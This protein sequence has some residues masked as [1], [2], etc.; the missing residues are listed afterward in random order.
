[1]NAPPPL[2]LNPKAQEFWDRHHDR[3]TAAGIL[4]PADVDSFAVLCV[5]WGKI[6]ALAWVEPGPEN[7]RQLIQL[8]RLTKQY[9]Q[10]ARQFGLTPLSR[11]AKLDGDASKPKDEFNL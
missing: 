9:A 2:P 8:D 10:M 7:Y 11:G 6:A 1:M 4:T 5:V 3:L